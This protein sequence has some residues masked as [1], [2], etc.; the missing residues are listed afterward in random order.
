MFFGDKLDQVVELVNYKKLASLVLINDH[1]ATNQ[2]FENFIVSVIQHD[3][4]YM[5]FFNDGILELNT[6][7]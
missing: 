4:D 7:V 1:K 2:D 6:N 5:L 3:I